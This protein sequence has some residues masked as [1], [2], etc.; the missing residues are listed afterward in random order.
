[1]NFP[2]KTLLVIS[3][4]LSALII[5]YIARVSII[6]SIS[7]TELALYQAKITCLN[8]HLSTD[9]ALTISALCIE[10]PQAKVDIR[11]MAI[12]L[13]LT[14]SQKIKTIDIASL[15]INGKAELVPYLI[16]A[17]RSS[18]KNAE[19]KP[20]ELSASQQLQAALSQLAQFDLPFDIAVKQLRYIPYQVIDNNK[21]NRY[22][23]S[24]TDISNLNHSYFGH[25]TANGSQL[26][27]RLQ[28]HQQQTLLAA[29]FSKNEPAA[30]E[31]FS[32]ELSAQLSLLTDFF[33]RHN[34]PLPVSITALTQAITANGELRSLINYQGDRLT[35]NNQLS[36]FSLKADTGIEASG[37]F[38]LSGALDINTEINFSTSHKTHKDDTE[39]AL[40]FPASNALQLQFSQPHLLALL[41]NN[42]LP[43]ELV[44][45]LK[46]N[47]INQFTLNPD[48][49]FFYRFKAQQLTLSSLKVTAKN[50]ANATPN[51][52]LGTNPANE[53]GKKI[54]NIEP[55]HQLNLNNIVLDLH[56]FITP[57][58]KSAKLAGNQQL[59]A[60]DAEKTLSNNSAKNNTTGNQLSEKNVFLTQL[61]FVLNS[62]LKLSA[63][64][65]FT[66][67]AVEIM[68]QGSIRQTQH[69]TLINITENSFLSNNNIAIV[70]EQNSGNKKLLSIKNIKN[71]LQG[72]IRIPDQQAFSLNLTIDSVASKLQVPKQLNINKLTLNSNITG[73]VN[74]IQITTLASADSVPL[75]TLAISGAIEKP[76]IAL[77]AK[78]LSLTDL[79]SLNM[80]LPVKVA[81]VDGTLS[82]SV[83]GQ[84]SD[85]SNIVNTP[86]VI[87]LTVASVSG[88]VEDIWLQELNWQ[89]NFNY[90]NAKL[91]TQHSVEENLTVALIDT[92]TPIAKLSINTALSYQKDFKIT[93]SQL[94]GN[95]LGG[96]FAIPNIQW[97]LEHSHSVDVQ[98]TSID[99]EQ[100]LALDKKQGIVVTG[101]VSGQLPIIFDG[102]K[103]TME[104]GELHNV[105]HGLIQ[106]MNNPA[107]EELKAN[108]SQL[109]LAFDALQNLHYHQ[110]SSDVSMADDGYM[111]LATVIKGRNPDIDNDVNLNLNLS[112]DLLGLLESMSITEQFE[113]RII[114]GLQK[115]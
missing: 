17:Q 19:K 24:K 59:S 83:T 107:V 31:N 75:G 6:N 52:A 5:G 89:Q 7:K 2:K 106:V 34:I 68:L 46:D 69:E 15:S 64:N 12:S 80:Q 111:L 85:L 72:D 77:T 56:Q 91:T 21:T 23:N 79:L 86:L 4:S 96:S 9:L 28:D 115:H 41:S 109:Q 99:L 30:Q 113:E 55:V 92:P 70:S 11:D 98:L 49:D 44:T 20:S 48:G 45:L 32:L 78:V 105:T 103:Y 102:E 73:N 38:K 25:F 3:I 39:L 62:S 108:N 101:S 27:M 58:H 95:I 94:K 67:E 112:Y 60:N 1:M 47:P 22:K 50:I 18:Q 104:K 110:L 42:D 90:Q 8:F 29:K 37:P 61:D 114:K 71:R 76:H 13:A 14:S 53:L 57:N 26:E 93:A 10:T 51:S 36:A 81:L 87:S 84:V 43:P 82:Y 33:S 88:E 40:H 54:N 35:L 16:D 65:N 97:P 74:N 63:I 66:S 100:V